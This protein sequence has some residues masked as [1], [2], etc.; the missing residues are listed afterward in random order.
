MTDTLK[1]KTTDIQE[2]KTTKKICEVTALM[3][4]DVIAVHII[5]TTAY[6]EKGGVF[7]YNPNVKVHTTK[8]SYENGITGNG[9]NSSKQE[10]D[11]W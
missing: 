2:E 3:R 9:I 6:K 11:A 4:E 10:Q 1:N 7:F 5:Y 8:K